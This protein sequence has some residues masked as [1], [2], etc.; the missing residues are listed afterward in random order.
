MRIARQ[1]TRCN[2]AP[3]RYL[4]PI[5]YGVYHN[6][7]IFLAATNFFYMFLQAFEPSSFLFMFG[8]QQ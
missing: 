6:D 1:I 3:L 4:Y 8:N 7:E 5:A 2:Q